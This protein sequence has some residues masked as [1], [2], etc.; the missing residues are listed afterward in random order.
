VV[1]L[2]RLLTGAGRVRWRA[3]RDASEKGA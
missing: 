3:P 2:V 1:A